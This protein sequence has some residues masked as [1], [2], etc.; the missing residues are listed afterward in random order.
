V[1]LVGC[2][3]VLFGWHGAGRGQVSGAV[4][5]L[6]TYVDGASWSWDDA[7]ALRIPWANALEPGTEDIGRLHE[8]EA[9]DLRPADT[10]TD[11][12][13]SS[14]SPVLLNG[15]GRRSHLAIFSQLLNVFQSYYHYTVVIV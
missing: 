8:G 1:D 7:S 15:R 2:F 11:S 12:S 10:S 6:A 3:A 13:P 5:E 14:L 9:L 4:A